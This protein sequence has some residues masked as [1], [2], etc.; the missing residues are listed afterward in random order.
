MISALCM[1]RA[2]SASLWAS[3]SGKEEHLAQLRDA[4][5]EAF[6]DEIKLGPRKVRATNPE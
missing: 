1:S 4:S 2:S 5:L 6:E 3:G